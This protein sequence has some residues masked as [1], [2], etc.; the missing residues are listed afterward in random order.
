MWW[1]ERNAAGGRVAPAWGRLARL[2]I[3]LAA[4]GLTAG[5]FQ[6]LLG[7]QPSAATESV[8]DKLAQI[9]VPV[10][11]AAKGQTVARIAV[12][13]RNSLQYGLSGAAG[14]NAPTY[15]LKVVV[16]VTALSV[17][18][19]V[20]S[21]RPDAQVASVIASYQLVEMATGKTVLSD[22]TF[23]HVDYDIP[24]AAQRFAKQRAERDAEDRATEVVSDTIRNRLASYFVAGT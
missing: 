23:A 12:A 17:I 5:C 11:P 15:T 14:A 22:S 19:D 13:L 24:G 7:S 18:V 1:F 21:G 2:A 9:D 8:R 3:V 6:P 4:A 16:A 20:T 10:I